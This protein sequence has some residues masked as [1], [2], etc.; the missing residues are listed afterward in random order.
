MHT[1]K[2][3][4]NLHVDKAGMSSCANLAPVGGDFGEGAVGKGV[5]A[6]KH[7]LD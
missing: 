3:P 1:K 6:R 2:R 5:T 4:K 7:Y